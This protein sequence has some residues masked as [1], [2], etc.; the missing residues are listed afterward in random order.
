M[1][2]KYLVELEKNSW[3]SKLPSHFQNVLL[4]HAVTLSVDKDQAVFY[5][6]DVFDGIYAVLEGAIGL[7]S[8]NIEG[9]EAVS[10]IVE[11]I[12]WFGEISLVDEQPRSHHAIACKKSLLLHIPAQFIYKL[13]AEQPAFWFHISQLMSQKLRYLFLELFSIQTQTMQQRLAQRL[14]F[15]LQ[16]YGNHLVIKN[17]TIQLSQEQLSQMLMCSRQTINQELQQLEKMNILKIAFKQIEILDV[18]RLHQLTGV[19]LH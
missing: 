18:Q 1:E 13:V 19:P 6:G 12:V 3:F 17:R 11:P 2:E 9:K 15:I 14:L 8:I 4:K 7:G 16:G 10:A 5:S